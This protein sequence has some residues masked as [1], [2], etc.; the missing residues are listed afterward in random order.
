M[1]KVQKPTF[2]FKLKKKGKS[3]MNKKTIS[4]ILIFFSF[5]L[6]LTGCKI[7]KDQPS[8]SDLETKQQE[9]ERSTTATSARA[10]RRQH[11]RPR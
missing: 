4:L 3:Y 6:V 9:I 2:Y 7:G 10:Q 8:G 11:R 1:G 5:V